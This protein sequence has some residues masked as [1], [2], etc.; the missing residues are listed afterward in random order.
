[1]ETIILLTIAVA[2]LMLSLVL[3]DD[4]LG[5]NEIAQTKFAVAYLALLVF[6]AAI[7]SMF[8]NR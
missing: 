3:P 5:E 2:L 4:K 7:L 8:I 6:L 1:M